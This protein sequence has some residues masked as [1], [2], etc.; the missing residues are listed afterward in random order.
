VFEHDATSTDTVRDFVSGVDHIE[1]SAADFG[2]GL[3]AGGLDPNAFATNAT[4]KPTDS[5]DRFVYD[6]SN[7]NLYFD[8]DGS[9]HGSGRELVA[10]FTGAATM[11]ASDFLIV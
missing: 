2:G 8:A 9:G 6:T 10:K 4:G 5:A 1:I 11:H 7:G 3:V